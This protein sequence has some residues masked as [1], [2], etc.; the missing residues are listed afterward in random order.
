MPP[1]AFTGAR[2]GG[3]AGRFEK[4]HGGTLLLDEIG[5]MP[6]EMQGN[7]LRVLEDRA[8]VRVGGSD[9]VPVDVRLV[10]ATHRDLRAEVEQG[11]FRRDLYYRISVV[12]IALP[13]LRDRPE[14]V[15]ELAEAY[16]ARLSRSLGR[17]VRSFHPEALEALEAYPWPGNVRELVNVIEQAVNLARGDLVLPEH[18]PE[19]VRKARTPESPDP[20]GP[21]EDVVPLASLEKWAIEQAIV[22]YRGNLTKVARALGIGRNTLYDKIKRY[23]IRR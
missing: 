10:A 11:R 5:D 9:P 17:R 1:W 3:R 4:A 8:V 21:G 18:L 22:R 2:P 16:L 23:E 13:P 12:T 15:P 19:A 7:L 20:S 6:L 14:D